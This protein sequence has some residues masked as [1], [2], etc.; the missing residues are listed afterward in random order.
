MTPFASL[1]GMAVLTNA[2]TIRSST[3]E[4]APSTLPAT[5]TDHRQITVDAAALLALSRCALCGNMGEE[6]PRHPFAPKIECAWC[7]ERQVVNERCL[8]W[9]KQK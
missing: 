6:K 9:L 7:R 3:R 4:T 1:T 8:R 5:P 2:L